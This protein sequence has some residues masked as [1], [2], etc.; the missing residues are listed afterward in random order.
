MKKT[1][2]KNQKISNSLKRYHKIERSNKDAKAVAGVIIL[3]L[4]ITS[5][6]NLFTPTALADYTEHYNP[7][8]IARDKTDLTVIDKIRII[9]TKYCKEKNID[10]IFCTND[11][12][13][14]AWVETKHICSKVGDNGNSRGCFQ[15][16]KGYHPNVSDEQA[17]DLEFSINWTL[18]RLVHYGYPE[19]RSYAIRR[20]NGSADNPKTLVYLNKVNN[21]LK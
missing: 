13:A 5:I 14:M 2:T 1:K 10:T 12:I 19:F 21:Y 17:E 4:Y 7:F 16:H 20:H 9:G 8:P 15:I 6:I 3:I 18:N 11:L